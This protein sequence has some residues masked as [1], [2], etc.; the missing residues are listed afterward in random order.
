MVQR[1][2]IYT[3]IDANCQL[4]GLSWDEERSGGNLIGIAAERKGHRNKKPPADF[5]TGGRKILTTQLTDYAE[6]ILQS[7]LMHET[8]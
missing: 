4:S 1:P 2:A 7:Y 5:S 8:S 3:V 6:T